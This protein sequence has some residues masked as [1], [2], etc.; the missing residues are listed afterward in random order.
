MINTER[1]NELGLTSRP[2]Y[3][4]SPGPPK[5]SYRVSD[6]I[7]LENV[8]QQQQNELNEESSYA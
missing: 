6:S 5:T 3:G 8:S 4:A 1:A 2:S 7:F